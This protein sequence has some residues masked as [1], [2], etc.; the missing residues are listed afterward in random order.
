MHTSSQGQP[1]GPHE[2]AQPG[3]PG[4]EPGSG[5]GATG[6]GRD[7]GVGGSVRETCQQVA[8]RRTETPAGL[9]GPPPRPP[10]SCPSNAGLEPRLGVVQDPPDSRLCSAA[11]RPKTPQIP[12]HEAPRAQ[13]AP[14][15]GGC[16]WSGPPG[17]TAGRMARAQHQ[18]PH[19]WG[20]HR[21]LPRGGCLG[22][23]TQPGVGVSTAPPHHRGQSLLLAPD[24]GI[25]PQLGPPR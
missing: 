20:P 15:P 1:R 19:W 8:A 6:A 10:T 23:Q 7:S 2:Q 16:T 13:G 9:S 11:P 4:S 18:A 24:P 25:W 3:L 22:P 14:R 12:G 17:G 21:C 5:C